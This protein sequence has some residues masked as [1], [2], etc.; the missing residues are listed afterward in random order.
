[1]VRFLI[2]AAIPIVALAYTDI[3]QREAGPVDASCL[4]IFLG[5][6]GLCGDYPSVETTRT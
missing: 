3:V 1:L 5:L 2:L 4:A 6:A